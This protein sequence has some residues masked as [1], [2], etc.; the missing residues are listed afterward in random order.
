MTYRTTIT[1]DDE[2]ATFLQ[3][4]GGGNKSAFISQLLRDERQRALRAAVI[5]ANL[6]EAQDADYQDK[7]SEWDITLDD[8]L[9]DELPPA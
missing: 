7:L 3:E 6:E 1:L 2:A 4:K 5:S 8:G 9:F